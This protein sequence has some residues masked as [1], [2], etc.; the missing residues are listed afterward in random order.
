M[1]QRDGGRCAFNGAHGRCTET[2]F[3]EYHHVVPF[4]E[5]GEASVSNI[6]LRCR[7]HNQYEAG[8][9]FGVAETPMVR[10]TRAVFGS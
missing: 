4:A 7:A 5:G 8:L 10:E 3:L 9:W 1:W 6:E 2:R